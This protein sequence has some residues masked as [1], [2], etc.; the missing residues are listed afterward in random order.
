MEGAS[1]QRMRRTNKGS[2]AKM[3][4]GSDLLRDV[5]FNRKVDEK[6]VSELLRFMDSELSVASDFY[7]TSGVYSTAIT[8]AAHVDSKLY[9][10]GQ[11]KM[12]LYNKSLITRAKIVVHSG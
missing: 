5:F 9:R 7:L 1:N 8:S 11:Q 12:G 3:A 4:A 2:L 10:S 6:V